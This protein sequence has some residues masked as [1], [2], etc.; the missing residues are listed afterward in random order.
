MSSYF[1][2]SLRIVDSALEALNL[3]FAYL[4]LKCNFGCKCHWWIA[5]AIQELFIPTLCCQAKA[6]TKQE[7]ENK[8]SIMREIHYLQLVLLG[9]TTKLICNMTLLGLVFGLPS[10]GETRTMQY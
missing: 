3:I 10:A 8:E 7:K 4:L 6:I 9:T 2:T 5:G 1:C